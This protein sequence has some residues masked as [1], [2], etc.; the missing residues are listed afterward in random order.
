MYVTIIQLYIDIY[1][2]IGLMGRVFVNGPREQSS[3]PGQVIPKI[4]KMVLGAA[5]LNIQHYKVWTKGKVEQSREWS[6]TLPYT[7]VQKL[8]KRELSGQPRLRSPTLLLTILSFYS[9]CIF[10]PSWISY[11][12]WV[13]ILVGRL[14]GSWHINRCR[15]FN[16]KSIFIQI[17][18]SFSNN[19]VSHEYIE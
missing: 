5:L 8:W 15:S 17:I 2:A 11:D 18:N 13:W 7:L 12:Q 16:T 19:S 4:Q 10:F 3:I 9:P 6:S 1:W 14:F